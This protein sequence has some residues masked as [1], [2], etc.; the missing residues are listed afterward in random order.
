MS[1]ACAALVLAVNRVVIML[2]AAWSASGYA[3]QYK[4][5]S[6]ASFWAITIHIFPNALS[7]YAFIRSAVIVVPN[8]KLPVAIILV[9]LVVGLFMIA[10]P[11]SA[12]GQQWLSLLDFAC[13]VAG[14]V[15]GALKVAK[16]ENASKIADL[17][18]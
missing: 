16:K 17:P 3:S 1:L 7:G 2:I 8:S 5:F 4:T 10:I 18:P 12:R 13:V 11:V 14:C 6:D 15:I 9:G